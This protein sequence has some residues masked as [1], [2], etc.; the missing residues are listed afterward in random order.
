MFKKILD[1]F[2]DNDPLEKLEKMNMKFDCVVMNPPYQSPREIKNGKKKGTLNDSIWDKFVD[3][4]LNITK[5]NGY[6]CFVH[7]SSW[8]KPEHYLYTKISE[9]KLS[10]LEMHGE[11]DG[12]K[13]FGAATRYDWYVLQKKRN[14]G[15]KTIVKDQSGNIFEIDLTKYKFLPNEEFDL[16]QSVISMDNEEKCEVLFSYS[17]YE[18]RKPWMSESENNEYK[19]PCIYSMTKEGFSCWFSSKKEDFFDIPKVILGW[20]RHLYPVIDMEGK[21][22]LTQNTFALKVSDINEAENIVKAINSDKFKK[23]LIATK[24]GQFITEW[25]MFK[26]FRKD[27]WKEFNL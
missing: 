15:I 2:R 11:A 26:Y 18:T 27:F 24:W 8:R 16:I 5:E 12:I 10:Y 4:S 22:G 20:G 25:R 7:P 17:A 14:D 21:Y 3:L 1:N 13:T 9:N 19:Y 23:V 6:M